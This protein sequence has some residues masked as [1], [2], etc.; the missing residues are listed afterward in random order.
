[1]LANSMAEAI[2]LKELTK[3]AQARCAKPLGDP[4]EIKGRAV[5]EV[6]F[7][8]ANTR[9]AGRREAVNGAFPS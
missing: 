5:A 9:R 4:I 2:A 6:S 3:S 8:A 7:E 1:M